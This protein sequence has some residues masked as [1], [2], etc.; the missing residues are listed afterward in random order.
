MFYGQLLIWFFYYES[1][2]YLF[3]IFLV[4]NCRECNT[5]T[6]GALERILEIWKERDVY[7]QIFLDRLK[8][9]MSKYNDCS[10]RLLLKAVVSLSHC[11]L[12]NHL[13]SQLNFM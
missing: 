1:F 3:Q 10:F 11:S 9:G 5:D 2:L 12:T 13:R 4:L 7:D 6:V 8:K